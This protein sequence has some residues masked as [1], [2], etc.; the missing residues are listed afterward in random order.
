MPKDRRLAIQTEDHEL[1]YMTFE[2][3]IPDNEYGAGDLKIADEG[4]YRQIAW[5]PDRIEVEHT[6]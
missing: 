1:S 3:R 6:G 4:T 2:G 5:S